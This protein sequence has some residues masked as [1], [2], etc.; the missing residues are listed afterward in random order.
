MATENAF[1]PCVCA[2]VFASVF[3]SVCVFAASGR[4]WLQHLTL[5]SNER[6]ARN[7][8]KSESEREFTFV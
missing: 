3:A 5:K 1:P 4:D 6:A 8:L 2:S 7:Q